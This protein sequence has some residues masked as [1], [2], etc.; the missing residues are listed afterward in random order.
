MIDLLQ[1]LTARGIEHSLTGEVSKGNVGVH[2]PFCG[3]DDGYHCGINLATGA[4]NCWRNP[5]HRGRNPARLIAALVPCSLQEAYRL[6]G[7]R[8]MTAPTDDV[9]AAALRSLDDKPEAEADTPIDWPGGFSEVAPVG[10]RKRFWQYLVKRG[11]SEEDISILVKQYDLR[12]G[13]ADGW[14][15]RLLLPVADIKG[16]VIAWTGR[17][18]DGG[19]VRYKSWPLGPTIKRLIWNLAELKKGG[20]RLY[21]CEGPLDALKVDFYGRPYGCAAT[22]LFGSQATREQQSLLVRTAKRFQ[23]VAV[24]LDA[25]ALGP[26]MT[27]QGQLAVIGAKLAPWPWKE[28]DPGALA[29]MQVRAMAIECL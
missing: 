15:N 4:W 16:Q 27:L 11:F 10:T 6:L 22:C 2:C 20:R 21:V 28:K 14:A 13:L 19:S 3:D 5:G 23:E 24:L 26:A 8:V 12:C 9:L 25:D 18:I 29:P 1:F 17:A 7:Q